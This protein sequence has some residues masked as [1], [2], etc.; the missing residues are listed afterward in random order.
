MASF[1]KFTIIEMI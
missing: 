1:M